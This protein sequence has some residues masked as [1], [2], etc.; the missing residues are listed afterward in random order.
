MKGYCFLVGGDPATA[1]D[2]VYK[3]L[4]DQG[5][6]VTQVDNWSANAERGSSGMSIAL[7]AFAGKSGRHTKLQI[8][9]QSNSEGLTITFIEGTSG[10]S[11]GLIGVKQANSIYKDIYDAVGAVFQKA[12]VLVSGK[13]L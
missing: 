1:R 6:T 7:G 4:T 13:P 12:G 3:A 11:G 10:V 2:T 9:C 5:F 8:K